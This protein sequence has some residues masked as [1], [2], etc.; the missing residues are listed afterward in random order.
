MGHF[1]TH[2]YFTLTCGST[3]GLV[4]G[5]NWSCLVE[6]G[7]RMDD[8]RNLP[9]LAWNPIFP[10]LERRQ[11][12]FPVVLFVDGHR[13]HINLAVPEFS[14]IPYIWFVFPQILRISFNLQTLDSSSLQKIT[15][16][17]SNESLNRSKHYNVFFEG[18]RSFDSSNTV[19]EAFRTC[20]IYLWSSQRNPWVRGRLAG[21]HLSERYLLTSSGFRIIHNNNNNNNSFVSLFSTS[22][23]LNLLNFNV[24]FA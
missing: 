3:N 13:Y 24:P 2:F 22:S 9:S 1:S 23:P 17:K 16:E 10:E 5:T 4:E 20:G 18:F 7:K 12:E 8:G 6:K 11:V 14:E 21:Y 15:G 19:R